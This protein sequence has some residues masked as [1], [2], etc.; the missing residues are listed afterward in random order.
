MSRMRDHFLRRVTERRSEQEDGKEF[1][2]CDDQPP[3]GEEVCAGTHG[4]DIVEE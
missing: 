4:R 1:D 2:D 3:E